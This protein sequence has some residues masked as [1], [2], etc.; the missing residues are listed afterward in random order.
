ML[1]NPPS[2]SLGSTRQDTNTYMTAIHSSCHDRYGHNCTP[3]SHYDEAAQWHLQTGCRCIF[4]YL[5]N[6]APYNFPK[7]KRKMFFSLFIICDPQH[8]TEWILFIHFV[9]MIMDLLK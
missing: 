2:L 9:A 8:I 4:V 7:L 1:I 5:Q 3:V 6:T